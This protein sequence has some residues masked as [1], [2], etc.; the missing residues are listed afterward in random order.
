VAGTPEEVAAHAGSHTGRFLAAVLEADR[1]AAAG[2]A[3]AD[4]QEAATRRA[5]P[6]R[7]PRR[8]PA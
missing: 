2:A 6:A 1:A 8:T 5:G 7:T 3:G 4:R